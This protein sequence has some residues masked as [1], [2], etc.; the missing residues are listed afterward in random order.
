[1]SQERLASLRVLA[2][3]ARADAR[4]HSEERL[5]IEALGEAEPG[6]SVQ[7]ALHEDTDLDSLLRSIV[8]PELRHRTLIEAIALANIDGRCS[9]V[10]L[11]VL[12]RIRDAFGASAEIDLQA[13]SDVWKRRTAR[14]RESLDA[15]TGAYLRKI[16]D[17]SDHAAL[18]MERYEHLVAELAE[19]K[20]G[21]ERAFRD[22]VE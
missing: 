15:A 2:H 19:A 6:F 13:D 14:I 4:I 10:E 12:T 5:A 1:M 17:E 18:S 22:A 11:A 7:K 21:I 9:P 8:S 3:V 16:H 20:R